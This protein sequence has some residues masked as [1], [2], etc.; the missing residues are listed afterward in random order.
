MD[1]VPLPIIVQLTLKRLREVQGNIIFS[2]C[3]IENR[4][5]DENVMFD[6][7][8]CSSLSS[9]NALNTQKYCLL[10]WKQLNKSDMSLLQFQKNNIKLLV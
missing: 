6:C 10:Q 8:F 5:G 1:H 7:L 2:I 9:L 3:D 4:S